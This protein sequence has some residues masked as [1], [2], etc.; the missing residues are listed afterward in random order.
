MQSLQYTLLGDGS[1]DRTLIPILD[2][3]LRVHL[4]E[5]TVLEQGQVAELGRL[6][7]PP[8]LGDLAGRIR[9]AVEYYPCDVE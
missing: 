9:T 6:P 2:W 4:P 3:L 1:S 8:P 5:R 7:A